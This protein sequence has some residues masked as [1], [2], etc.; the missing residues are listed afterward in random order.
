MKMNPSYILYD[1]QKMI[2]VQ[3]HEF[4]LWGNKHVSGHNSCYSDRLY[5][6]NPLRFNELCLKHFGNEGQ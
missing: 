2:N 3:K 5:Q 6:L 1:P 4:I